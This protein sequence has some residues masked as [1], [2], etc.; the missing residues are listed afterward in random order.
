MKMVLKMASGSWVEVAAVRR[1]AGAK[2]DIDRSMGDS[3]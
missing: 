2:H 1:E 3:G